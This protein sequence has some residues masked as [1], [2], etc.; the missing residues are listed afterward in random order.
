MEELQLKSVMD[1]WGKYSNVDI[2]DVIEKV[3]QVAATDHPEEFLRKRE[4]IAHCLYWCEFSEEEKRRVGE[5]LRIKTS[6][7]KNADRKSESVIYES[8]KKLHKMGLSFKVV[9]AADIGNTVSRLQHHASK[10]V[11]QIAEVIIGSWMR[12]AMFDR[13]VDSD[14]KMP[15]LHQEEDEQDGVLKKNGGNLSAGN[16]D[17]R[18]TKKSMKVRIKMKFGNKDTG[19]DEVLT[20]KRVLGKRS[21]DEFE[22]NDLLKKPTSFNL[23]RKNIKVNSE[24]ESFPNGR[25]EQRVR[26]INS[27]GT[28]KEKLEAARRKLQEATKKS[29]KKRSI[30]FLQSWEVNT[31]LPPDSQLMKSTNKRFR[32]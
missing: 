19:V 13:W 8:L 21:R 6:L 14:E 10:Q 11:K 3:I 29:E 20:G 5:V 16:Q 7:E 27:K 32:R 23:E 25:D 26:L 4:E 28:M 18:E 17:V 9:D 1:E 15:D 30:Q 24:K 31:P 2:F 12:R 22:R